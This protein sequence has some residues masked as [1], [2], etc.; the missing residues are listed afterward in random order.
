MSGEPL[1]AYSHVVS[2]VARELT[3]RVASLRVRH[4]RR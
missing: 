4:G 2:T 1:D 3:P